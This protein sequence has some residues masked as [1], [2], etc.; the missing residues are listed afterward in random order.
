M[1]GNIVIGF[2]TNCY[3]MLDADLKTE[4][5]VEWAREY[6]KEHQLGSVLIMKT[7]RSKQRDLLGNKLTN[8]CI[9][10]GQRLP[11]Q[12][13]IAHIDNAYKK[14]IINKAFRNMRKYGVIIERINRKN[15][16]KSCPAIFTYIRAGNN[17]GCME[18]LH[19]WKWNKEIGE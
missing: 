13:I 9:I 14:G 11:W 19:W 7:S 1:S 17:E 2:T 16:K 8:Y 15:K 4:E 3:L 5:A 6:S 18:Y 10:F 12:E